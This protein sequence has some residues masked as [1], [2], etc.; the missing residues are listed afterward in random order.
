MKIIVVVQGRWLIANDCVSIWTKSGKCLSEAV[1]VFFEICK[2]KIS[3]PS[4]FEPLGD[5]S[6][7]WDHIVFHW[8]LFQGVV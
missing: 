4:Y 7:K 1:Y 5:S 3:E 2:S 6:V 8:N